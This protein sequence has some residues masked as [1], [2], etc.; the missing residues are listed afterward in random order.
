M[1]LLDRPITTTMSVSATEAKVIVVL[2]HIE[3]KD[4][5]LDV[6]LELMRRSSIPWSSDLDA[7]IKNVGSGLFF[8]KG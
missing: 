3:N 5:K 2:D 4:V 8:E 1:E 6:L 7:K